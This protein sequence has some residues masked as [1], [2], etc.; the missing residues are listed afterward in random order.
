M[1][2]GDGASSFVLLLLVQP[3]WP[4]TLASITLSGPSGSVSLDGES[5]HPMAI[6]RNPRTGQ[7]RGILRDLPAIAL[8]KATPLRR[9]P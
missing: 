2:H 7:V 5:N 1:A 9:W 4:E 8:A 3:G 6:L